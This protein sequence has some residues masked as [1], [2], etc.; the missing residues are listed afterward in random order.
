MFSSTMAAK[1]GSESF[2]FE[3][4][5]T[6]VDHLQRREYVLADG[7]RVTI[8]FEQCDSF[9][10]VTQTFDAEETYNYELQR[11]GWQL[12]LDSVRR[13]VEAQTG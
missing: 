4:T 11:V 5:Y 3:G 12:S 7:R 1:D 2:D 6:D 13:H 10:A 9:T 8:E